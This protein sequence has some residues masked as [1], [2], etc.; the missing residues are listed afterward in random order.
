MPMSEH[1]VLKLVIMTAAVVG[2]SF[3]PVV[4]LASLI[5]PEAIKV[6][7]YVMDDQAGYAAHSQR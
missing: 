4:A 1:A 5:K 6:Y 2:G 3:F 7:M